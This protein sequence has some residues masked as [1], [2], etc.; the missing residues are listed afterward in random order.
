MNVFTADIR[1]AMAVWDQ[2][3][4]FRSNW[5]NP[6]QTRSPSSR[7]ACGGS[8]EAA[9]RFLFLYAHVEFAGMVV[10]ASLKIS[11]EKDAVFVL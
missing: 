5:I 2:I 7:V 6:V 10:L 9:Q 3:N 1:C 8:S 11:S 4:Q